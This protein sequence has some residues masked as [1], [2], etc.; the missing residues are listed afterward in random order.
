MSLSQRAGLVLGL[1]LA[2]AGCGQLPQP[3]LGNPG[4]TALRLGQPPAPR[5]AVPVPMEAQL[6]PRA[7][8]TFAAALARALQA[9]QV[10]AYALKP[11]STDWRLALDATVS[12]G[13]VLPRYMLFM[14]QGGARGSVTGTPVAAAAW[15][16]GDPATLEAAA[17]AVAPRIAQL[18]T[19]VE[20]ALMRAD[21]NSLM[22]RPARVRVVPVAGAPG[23]GDRVL[24]GAMRR[25]LH[26]L[27]ESVVAAR[28]G[29]PADFLVRGQVRMT[30]LPGGKQ[31]VELRWIVDTA[32]GREGGRVFQLNVVT[33]G[34]LDHN[35]R[36]V[37][38]QIARQAAGGIREI[39]LR[40]SRRE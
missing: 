7:A 28:G 3:F 35:W 26:A 12:S 33:A 34:S 5:L 31:R 17:T 4:P 24:A 21:P 15:H 6:S 18:L 13:M 29:P 8:A 32:H 36:R 11:A 27:G 30:P 10:P 23:N 37:A 25:A 2:L 22:N 19:R 38:P 20:I 9:Q 16:A 39:V 40:Q 1:V 14:P